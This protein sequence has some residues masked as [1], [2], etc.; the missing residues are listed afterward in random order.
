M[1][2]RRNPQRIAI[3]RLTGI[4]AS[5]AGGFRGSFTRAEALGEIANL[6]EDP[7]VLAEAAA[8]YAA[9]GYWYGAQAVDLLIDAGADHA[10]ITRHVE[11]RRP[12]HRRSDLAR[13]ADD[14]NGTP[15]AGD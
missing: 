8:M 1:A 3:A 2:P 7:E 5:Y 10:A 12:G 15:S 6:S 9:G 4:A 11:Q 14:A 13:L